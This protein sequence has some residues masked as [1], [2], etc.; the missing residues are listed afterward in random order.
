MR[1]AFLRQAASCRAL[2]SD[3]TARLMRLCAA[4]LGGDT[5][6]GAR[7]LNWDGPPD[8]VGDSV[9][10]RLASG[11]HALALSGACPAVAAVWSDPGAA[12]DARIWAAVEVALADHQPAL[13]AAL[14]NP[15]QTNEVR[16]AAALIAAGH[17]L[18][19]AT[20][21]PI[22]LAELGAAAG[23]NL[24]WDRF[25][26]QA[27][28]LTLGPADA[29]VRLAPEWR[30]APATLAPP[31]VI[32]RAGVDLRPLDPARDRLRALSYIW[33]DQRDRLARTAA[34]LDLAAAHPVRVARGDAGAWLAERLG[35]ALP[36][37]LRLVYHTIAWQYFPRAT[38]LR[39]T[40]ALARAGAAARPD[41]PLARL[42]MEAD[43]AGP[44]AALTLDLWAGRARRRIALGRIDFHGR[45]VDWSA[46]AP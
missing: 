5:P 25:A 9:P 29:P 15:P 7:I 26:L 3:F 16:R 1:A 18:T 40:R 42:G 38:R 32:A 21:L 46:P 13:L 44:G 31:R 28:G 35:Q 30:G 17:W 12:D 39:A 11:L 14:D 23:L 19:A 43:E 33:P 22:G 8:M 2:G 45:W 10:L 34:A 4:R 24:H 41:A 6:A 27:G 36:G 20:G 37:A